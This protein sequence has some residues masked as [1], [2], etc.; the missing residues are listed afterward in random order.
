MAF[1]FDPR[2]DIVFPEIVRP[3]ELEKKGIPDFKSTI[4]I[5]LDNSLLRELDKVV[6][7]TRYS[8]SEFIS[9]CIEFTLQN[10]KLI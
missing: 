2:K 4:R 5:Y 1:K 8:R 10:S 9:K 6:G 7:Q 3:L